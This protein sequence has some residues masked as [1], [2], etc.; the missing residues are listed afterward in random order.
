MIAVGVS[1]GGFATVALS[2]DPPAGLVAAISFAGGRGSLE[3]D[4]VCQGSRLIEAFRVFGKHSR[5]PM[6]WVYAVN[7]HFFGPNLAQQFLAAFAA[8]GGIVD[9][10]AAPA[11]GSDGHGLFSPGGIPVWTGYVD[12]FLKD[13]NLAMRAEP[14]PIAKPALTAP[15]NLSANGRKAFETYLIDAPHKAFALS[16]NGHYGWQS[17][18]RT[19]ELAR[20]GALKYCQ[21]SGAHCE[22]V[23]V[24]DAAAAGR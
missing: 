14:L 3:S 21:Q 2:A 17:G 4:E 5:V 13:H 23:F 18:V 24:D 1:A 20:T 7:D 16:Q 8:G 11:F 9:F 6:L 15:A 22:V 10:I 19:T 12:A